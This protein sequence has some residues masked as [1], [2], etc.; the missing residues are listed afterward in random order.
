MHHTAICIC[1]IVFVLLKSLTCFLF[2]AKIPRI[3]HIVDLCKIHSAAK[4]V[5]CFGTD[6]ASVWG[7]QRNIHRMFCAA[8]FFE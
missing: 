4:E 3:F 1:H 6:G 8:E 2:S 5:F 7:K